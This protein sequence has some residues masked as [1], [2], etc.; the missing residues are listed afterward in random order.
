MK[1]HITQRARFFLAVTLTTLMLSAVSFTL[2]HEG[3]T[4]ASAWPTLSPITDGGGPGLGG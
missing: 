4:S 3:M 2:T 1:A